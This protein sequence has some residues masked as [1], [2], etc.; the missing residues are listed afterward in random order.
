MKKVYL[1]YAATTPLD[2]RVWEEIN[3][4]ALEVFGNPSSLH[5]F[6][7]S[8]KKVLEGCREKV[9]SLIGA[10]PKEIVFTCGGTESNNWAL[11]GVSWA[12]RDKGNK[13]IVSSI[14][15]HSITRVCKT[16]ENWGFKVYYLKTD[17]YGRVDPK[18]VE[19]SIDKDTILV[20]VMHA[21][22][23]IGTIQDIKAI[24]QICRSRGVYFHT[25][26]VQSVGHIPVDVEDL[27]VDLLSSSAHK[28][29]GPKGVGF[30]YIREG[31]RIL[32][33]MEGGGQEGRR[34]ASTENLLGIVG[35]CKA[36]EIASGEREGEFKRLTSLRDRLIKR[37]LEEVPHSRLNGHPAQRLPNNVNISFE[38]VE[39]ESLVMSLDMEGV[40]CSTGSACSSAD[41]EPSHVLLSIGL[42]PQSAHGSLRIT[43]GRYTRDEDIDYVLEVLPRVVKRLR[44]L[45]PLRP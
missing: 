18:E 8:A 25:D 35:L 26:A 15:H 30:L 36:L 16:L 5:Y 12:N 14:E 39:G 37:I 44:S 4:Y 20:S 34:R 42:S 11:K 40:S 29:Y 33:F 7:R 27:G 41:L 2:P 10:K 45:S 19:S 17:S 6:G 9:S 3:K 32:P 43:L 13:I 24:S 31:V 38:Y 23:E 1:D 28:F 21:N 22:N